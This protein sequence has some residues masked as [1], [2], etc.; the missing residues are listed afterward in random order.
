MLEP[1]LLCRAGIDQ[2]RRTTAL[3]RPLGPDQN[4]EAKLVDQIRS[5]WN[6][7]LA[8]LRGVEAWGRG[9]EAVG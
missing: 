5:S 8:W 7:L 6:S 2:G 1:E 4:D 3:L 9:A